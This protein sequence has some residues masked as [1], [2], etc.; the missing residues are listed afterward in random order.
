VSL[1]AKSALK[2]LVPAT[3]K[4][5]TDRCASRNQPSGTARTAAPVAPG[6]S[7]ERLVAGVGIAHSGGQD[8]APINDNNDVR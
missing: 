2:T 8:G 3:T 1:T 4:S 7:R 5:G 6:Q